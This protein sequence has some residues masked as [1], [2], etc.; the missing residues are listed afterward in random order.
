MNDQE[1]I[2]MAK[3]CADEIRS[4]RRRLAQVEPMADAYQRIATVLDLLPK[5]SVIT[6]RMRCAGT[7]KRFSKAHGLQSS[8]GD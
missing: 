3:E 5:Q 2:E 1:F 6:S 7:T 4:L 8:A